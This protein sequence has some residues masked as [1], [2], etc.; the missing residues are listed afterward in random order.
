MKTLLKSTIKKAVSYFTREI[1]KKLYLHNVR[2]KLTWAALHSQSRG[3]SNNRICNEELII[4]LTSYGQRFHDA[5]LA[6]ESIMEGSVLPDRIILWVPEDL[7]KEVCP[8]TLQNQMRR[9]LEIRYCRDLHSYTKLIYALK[10]FSDACIVTIDDDIIYP[11]DILENL[12][13]VHN[14]MP[15]VICANTIRIVP[16]NFE[17]ASGTFTQLGFFQNYKQAFEGSCLFEGYSGVLYPPGSLSDEVFNE[18]VFLNE[19]KTADDVWFSA[20]AMLAH[21]KVVYANPHLRSFRGIVNDDVQSVA[22]R[23]VNSVE[24]RQNDEQ[25]IRIYNRYNVF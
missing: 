20:M 1:E 13:N 18:D 14:E 7:R 9:G 12:V 17:K 21:T 15:D 23:I 3:V 5:Y 11:F 24:G 25:I 2:D 16:H 8:Q 10:E 4:S 22:L 6:I 19:C